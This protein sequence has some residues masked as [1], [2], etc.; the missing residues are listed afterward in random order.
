MTTIENAL[1]QSN[2]LSVS[3]A[4][5][6]AGA[7]DK[8]RHLNAKESLLKFREKD[9]NL[10]FVAS[11]CVRLFVINS[12]GDEINLGFGYENTLITCFQSFIEEKPS[13]L[14]IEA[15]L[16]TALLYIPKISLNQLILGNVEIGRWYQHMLET[17]LIGH[18]QR[19][20]ELLTLSPQARYAIFIKRSGHL[21]NRIP[22]KQIASYLMMKPETLSRIRSK[23][24]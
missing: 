2:L 20:V 1:K 8:S 14:S 10:Y 7:W 17:T 5:I 21:V 6:L 13:Q 15:V 24:S 23:I 3:S 22:L 11:G 19:Q 18:I 16:D 9:T 12:K 4:A